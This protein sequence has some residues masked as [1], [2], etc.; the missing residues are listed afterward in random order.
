MESDPACCSTLRKNE[1]ELKIIEDRIENVSSEIILQTA[2]LKPL[3]AA[4]VIGG[5]PCQP[6]SLAGNRKGLEDP[7]GYLIKEF[8]RVVRETL[9][10]GFVFE[11]VRG[12]LNWDKGKAIDL[13]IEELSKPIAHDGLIYKYTLAK[14][15]VLN[16]VDFG[17]PQNRERVFIVGNRL[18]KSFTFPNP[19]HFSIEQVNLFGIQPYKTVWDA[20]KDL[21]VPEEPS[22]VARR[23]SKKIKQR[24]VNHGY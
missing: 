14:P 17:V 6:F 20:I 5:P 19:T 3:E 23:V 8:I 22:E 4:L 13:I 18:G 24:I 16:A 12:L 7:R 15:T 10:V 9:P 2:N 1:P 21:P 11:N